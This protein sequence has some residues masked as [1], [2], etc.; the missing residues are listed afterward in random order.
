[1]EF[2][3][4]LIQ[5]F[6]KNPA[7]AGKRMRELAR[8]NSG[9]FLSSAAPILRKPRNSPGF[10]YLLTVLSAND[11]A[12]PLLSDAAA[13]SVEEGVV[14]ARYF[15]AAEPTFAMRLVRFILSEKTD[16]GPV[17]L[18]P[19]AARLLEIIGLTVERGNI[20]NLMPLLSHPDPHV[21]S[22]VALMVGRAMRSIHWAGEQMK[23]PDPRVR[24]NVIESLWGG[25]SQECRGI[26]RTAAA[27][28]NNR[29]AG[30]GLL[31]LYLCGAAESVRLIAQM[32]QAEAPAFRSTAA[33]TM[34][35]TADPRFVPLLTAM[36][37]DEAPGVRRS[38]LRALTSIRN[39]PPAAGCFSIVLTPQAAE[40]EWQ[41][42]QMDVADEDGAPVCGLPGTAFACWS[43]DIAIMEYDVAAEA[44]ISGRY[45]LHAPVDGAASFRVDVRSESASGSA[46]GI[47]VA[48]A[49]NP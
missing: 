41:A 26:F 10:L 24:A 3:S 4:E 21:Q 39:A 27:D 32:A 5:T 18:S 20:L 8:E 6:E 13:F 2:L 40:L 14:V 37:P 25:D 9:R 22:R 47:P 38:V 28:S 7:V 35:R 31:G 29:V 19:H 45:L 33:W 44:A 30:N 17:R 23:S 12:I 34:G 46:M 43:G 11:L 49:M 15:L 36:V 1:M 48:S 16:K 42:F